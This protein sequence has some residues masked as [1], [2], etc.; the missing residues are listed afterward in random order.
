MSQGRLAEAEAAYRQ[1]LETGRRADP[2][3]VWETNALG[4]L[5]T[6]KGL[7]KDY[8]AARDLAAQR[9]PLYVKFYGPQRGSTGADKV[10]WAVY[11]AKAG[12]VDGALAMLR[13]AMPVVRNGYPAGSLRVLNSLNAGAQILNLAGRFAEAESYAREALVL[14]D[15]NHLPE[16]DLRRAASWS[17]LA[18]ALRDQHKEREAIPLLEKA[19]DF[20]EHYPVKGAGVETV[21]KA[22][23]E[24]RSKLARRSGGP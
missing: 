20:Y 14:E 3:G 18:K 10:T 5:M 16:A 1:S 17:Q 2:G 24:L 4:G 22:L 19:L 21:R 23:E 9:H 15:R 12:D 7:R 6:L 11:T 13:E 8:A